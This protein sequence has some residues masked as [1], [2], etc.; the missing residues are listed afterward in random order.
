[1]AVLDKMRK[2]ASQILGLAL[3]G[4]LVISFAVWGIADIFTGYGAQTL[5]RVGDTELSAQDYQR[6]QQ[7]ILRSM[8]A[9]AGRS[10]SLQ[11]ARALGLDDRVMERLIGGA[12]VDAHAKDLGLGITD[13]ALL[14]GITKDPAF[15]DAAGNFSPV[16][17]AQTLRNIGMSEQGYLQA[18]RENNLRRQLLTTVG[19]MAGSPE[20]L[21]VALN[22]YNGETRVLRYVL[23]PQ[24]AAGAIPDPTEDDLKRYYENHRAK[25]TQ[26]EFRKIGVLAVTPETVKDQVKITE[27]DLKAAY[28]ADKDTLGKPEKRLVQQITFPDLD[29]AKAAR[30]KINAGTDFLEVAKAQGLSEAD[31]NLGNVTR[32]ELADPVIAEEVF[33]L[34]KDKVSEPVTGKLGN[35]VLLRVTAIEPGKSLTF[36]EAKAELEK[37]ILK[38]RASGAIF[39]LH[40]KVEDELASGAQLSEIA[41]KFKL[42]YQVIDQ[43]DRE[44]KRP[45]GSTVTLPAQKEVLN[46]AFATDAGVENDAIDAKDEGVIW[47]EV[48]GVTPEQLKPF[49]EV[50]ADVEKGWRSEETRNRMAKYAQDLITSLNSGKTLEDIAKDLNVEV[51]T[52]DALKRDGL[53]ANILPATVARA[54]ALPEGGYGSAPSGIDEGRVVF[55]VD[56]V[57]APPPVDERTSERLKQ[58]LAL[59]MSEDAISEYF[60]ALENRYGVTVNQAALDKLTGTGEEP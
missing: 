27:A 3:I 17:F 49:E 52:S 14:E 46:A 9:Q 25:F 38:E 41:D 5:I 34:E 30:E 23:V 47:Y 35:V 58:Q 54:F 28:D 50:K 20:V 12:A 15:Q 10:L 48:L 51:L 4:L 8:S 42:T 45:D 1:M 53:T 56:K 6:A 43:V 39:D 33:K 19:T 32:A 36:E 24:S 26:P 22:R 29:A 11:E 37:K 57:T 2:G 21:I 40:D 60:A 7:E 59:L 13:A 31:I 44:G 16:A 55:K 18:M